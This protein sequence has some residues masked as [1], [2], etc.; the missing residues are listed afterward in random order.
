[1][2][3][4]P[5]FPRAVIFDWDNTLV[6]NWPVI[7]TAINETFQ[8]FGMPVWTLDEV[9]QR[10]NRAARDSFPEWFGNIWQEAHDFFYAR[11]EASHLSM[12]KKLPGAED[13]LAWLLAEKVPAFVVS[14]KRGD[15][16]R[17]QSTALDWDK[18]FVAL[19]GSQDARRDKPERDPVDKV[20]AF[21]TLNADASVWFVGDTALDVLCAKNA[22]CFPVFIGN[23]TDL[24][25][26]T[27]VLAFPNCHALKSLL[28]K[29]H[30]KGM[31]E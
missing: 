15:F 29:L 28:I 3:I 23:P 13:L 30:N 21:A 17:Q 22:G 19:V 4:E 7:A 6:D 14:N 5:T 12:L 8:K 25:D 1:M 18:Y 24:K 10:C 31:I 2:A 26:Q 27:P 9:K 16:L 20:L 11:F